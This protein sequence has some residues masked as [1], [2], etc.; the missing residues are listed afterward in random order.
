M[1]FYPHHI[2]DFNNDTRH[3]TRI[4]RS[5]YRDL[6]ELYYDT[7]CPLIPDKDKLSRLVLASSQ[8]ELTAVE[9]VLNEFF[10]YTDNGYFHSRCHETICDYKKNIKGKSKAGIASAKARKAR[11][12]KAL[13]ELTDVEQVLDTCV[14]DVR[15]QKPETIN[16]KPILKTK[17]KIPYQLIADAYE[18]N[19]SE[20]TGNAGLVPSKQWSS[21]RKSAIKKLWNLDTD[22]ELE[23]NHTNNV[24]HWERYFDYCSSIGFFQGDAARGGD[25][26]NW[27]AS[28][29]FLIKIDTYNSNK[30]RKYS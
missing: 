18:K 6:I 23:K 4:E 11:K 12:L 8:D 25:H 20:P 17:E 24:E 10:D 16:Q 14:T 22:N 7:E 3:L 9:Q 21:K 13:S 19:Y 5:I 15:N 27:K 1:N 28:F 30:E 2:G 26:S 29:D